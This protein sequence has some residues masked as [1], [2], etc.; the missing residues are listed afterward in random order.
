MAHL[1]EFFAVHA[2][3]GAIVLAVVLAAG[4]VGYRRFFRP[5]LRARAAGARLTLLDAVGMTMRGVGFRAVADAMADAAG[6]GTRI[7]RDLLESHALIGGSVP[8]LARAVVTAHKAGLDIEPEGLAAQIL[9]GGNADNVLAGLI[10]AGEAGVPLNYF[11]ACGMDFAGRDVARDVALV[12][13]GRESPAIFNIR[14]ERKE[15]VWRNKNAKQTDKRF[16]KPNLG[17]TRT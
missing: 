7:S 12:L 9:A 2:V 15:R 8:A 11:Q 1:M 10:A 4:I 17:E 13:E 5:W 3:L 16:D 14:P 6:A